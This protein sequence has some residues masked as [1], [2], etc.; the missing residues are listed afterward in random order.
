LAVHGGATH[1]INPVELTP[2]ELT[3]SGSTIDLRFA[4]RCRVSGIA[5]MHFVES[6][7][8]PRTTEFQ[9]LY[10]MTLT[11][12]STIA[13]ILAVHGGANCRLP[14]VELTRYQRVSYIVPH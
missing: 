12:L 3:I 9:Q 6:M 7:K 1:R 10:G 5:A 8:L 13:D 14:N 4:C 2:Y 11:S